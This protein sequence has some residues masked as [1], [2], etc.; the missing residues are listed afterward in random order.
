LIKGKTWK[1]EK[2]RNAPKTEGMIF[3]NYAWVE[4]RF[5]QGSK[6]S[7]SIEWS[8]GWRFLPR[9]CLDMNI[10]HTI[11]RQTKFFIKSLLFSLGMCLASI[12]S[13]FANELTEG[14]A[15]TGFYGG[16]G[17]AFSIE[18]F[19][20]EK[21]TEL[22]D[23]DNAKFGYRGHPNFAVEV[24]TLFLEEFDIGDIGFD[25]DGELDGFALSV[26]GKGYLSTGAIQAYGLAGIGWADM[27]AK[28]LGVKNKSLSDIFAR[29]GVG[30]DFYLTHVVIVY[31]EG[32]Y[33]LPAGGN[34]NADFVPFTVGFQYRF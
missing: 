17:G 11:S 29:L 14:F 23:I 18:T 33:V 31:M 16:V 15:R 28:I 26:N 27:D 9:L 30:V 6:P 13:C 5:Y 4:P 34:K 7:Q 32:S 12:L 22:I 24:D 1:V 8:L 20:S 21:T 19:N 2:M 25:G 3:S 10:R